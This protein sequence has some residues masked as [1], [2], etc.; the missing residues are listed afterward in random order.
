MTT[1]A[2]EAGRRAWVL[3]DPPAGGL[4]QEPAEAVAPAGSGDVRLL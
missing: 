1:Y 3:D 4:A 2:V